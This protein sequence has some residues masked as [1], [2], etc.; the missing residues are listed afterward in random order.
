LQHAGRK[1]S[2]QAPWDGF[3]P[4]GAEDAARGEVPWTAWGP[5]AAG[6]SDAYPPTHPIDA[7]DVGYL[8]DCYRR[9]TGLALRAGFDAIEIHA[10]HGYLLHS[11]LSPLANTR[12]DEFGGPLEGRMRF[13]LAVARVVREAWPDERPLLFRMSCVDGESIG[14]SIDDSIALARRLRAIGVDAID[15]TSGGMS[16][17]SPSHLVARHPGFQVPFARAIREGAG[18]PTVAVGLIRSAAQAN[19]IVEEGAADLVALAREALWNPNFAAQAAQELG[20]DPAWRSWPRQFGWW[21]QRRA[22]ADR[23]NR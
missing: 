19:A 20:A 9:A 4:L 18:M 2:S 14:W 6:W 23:R 11:F 16:L 22:R 21:L 1:A 10:A 7:A 13:P 15:C 17:P 5:T 3:G 8:I 12:S